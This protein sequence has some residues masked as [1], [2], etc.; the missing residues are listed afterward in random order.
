MR[1]FKQILWRH[2]SRYYIA[3]VVLGVPGS[4]LLSWHYDHVFPSHRKIVAYS[5]FWSTM[6]GMMTIS[7]AYFAWRHQAA[8]ALNDSVSSRGE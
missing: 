7:N 5:V 1:S 4:L 3:Q 6:F 2:I 8:P